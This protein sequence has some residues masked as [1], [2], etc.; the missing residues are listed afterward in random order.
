M[1]ERVRAT[2]RLAR[3]RGFTLIEALAAFAILTAVLAQLLVGVS[4]AARNETRA[5]FLLRASRQGMSQLETL[6]ADGAL[7][8]GVTDGRYDDGLLWRLVVEP[9]VA[10]AAQ[11]GA[12]TASSYHVQLAI[13]RPDGDGSLTLATVKILSSSENQ[14]GGV[15]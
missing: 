13:R 14:I 11:L 12:P 3:R 7:P 6:G 1:R 10:S 2:L 9:G 4:G 15:Q 5:D 8:M